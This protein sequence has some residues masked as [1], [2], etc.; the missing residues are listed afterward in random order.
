MNYRSV[1]MF[2]K[3][4]MVS[5]EDK[6]D[7]LTII[8]DQIV[9]GRWQDARV[10]KS[11]ESKDTSVMS[12]KVKEAY[13]KIRTGPPGDDKEDY[14]LDFWTGELPRS[15]QFGSPIDDPLSKEGIDVPDYVNKFIKNKNL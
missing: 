1:V 12:M 6:L 14:D 2:G 15:I 5:D 4:E 11:K 13:A 9:P 10:P 8:S 3:A 7:A